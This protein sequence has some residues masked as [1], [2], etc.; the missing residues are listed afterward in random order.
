M[1]PENVDVARLSMELDADGVA[2]GEVTGGLHPTLEADLIDV[3]NN[4]GSSDFGSVGMIVL[5]ETPAATSDLRDIAQ[6]ALM[7]SNVETVI[8]RS[9]HSAAVVSDVH[10]RATLESGQHDLLSTWDYVHGT[11]LLI[12]D[13]TGSGLMGINWVLVTVIG[14]VALALTIAVIAVSFR[15]K[16]SLST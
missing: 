13:V 3:L 10:S 4:A 1:I 16:A 11:K 7:Q 9:P 14:L 8:V 2:M 5:D 15:R 6:E 12:D